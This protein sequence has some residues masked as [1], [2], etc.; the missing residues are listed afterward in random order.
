MSGREHITL[1]ITVTL[2]GSGAQQT[3]YLATEGFR[4]G[5]ADTPPTTYFAELVDSIGEY[6]RD[7]FSAARVAG[8]T[9]P[10]RL[11]ITLI[12]AAGVLDVFSRVSTGG[13]VVARIGVPGTAYP[14]AY[15]TLFVAYIDTAPADFDVVRLNVRDR[16]DLLDAPIVTAAFAGTGG[17]EGTVTAANKKQLVFGQPG[18]VPMILLDPVNQIYYVQANATDSNTIG[19]LAEFGHVFEG[20]VP[21]ERGPLYDSPNQLLGTE[22]S[23]GQYRMWSGIYPNRL[24]G[25]EFL[26]PQKTAVYTK[27]PIYVRLK[28]PP[29]FDLRFGASG[30]LQNSTSATPR[31]WRFTDMCNRAGM[32]DVTPTALAPMA[33]L[34]ED[35]DMGNRFIDG[36]QTYLDAMN[37]RAQ[38][39]QGAFGFD[40][41]DRFYCARLL[42]PEDGADASVFEFNADNSSNFARTPVPGMENPAWQVSVRAG[43]AHPGNLA[44]GASVEMQDILS[45]QDYLTSFTGTSDDVRKRFPRAVSVSLEIDGHDFPTIES[46]Q[47]FVDTFGRL[48]GTQRDFV[49]LTCHRFDSATRGIDLLSKVTLRLPR[50]GFDAGVLMR[51]VSVAPDYRSRTIRF[52][53]WGNNSGRTEWELGGGHYPAGSGDPGGSYGGAEIPQSVPS[54]TQQRD[55]LGDI[56]GYFAGAI[57]LAGALEPN[58]DSM[59]GAFT[60][61]IAEPAGDPYFANVALLMHFNGANNSSTATDSSSY[62]DDKTL[63]S[64]YVISTA[65]SK[66]N[67][68]SLL[69]PDGVFGVTPATWS[70]DSRYGRGSGQG[71]TIEAWV[72]QSSASP[73]G[74]GL[75]LDD[76]GSILWLLR[77]TGTANEWEISFRDYTYSA[78]FTASSAAWH[79]AQTVIATDG[80]SITKFDG[81]TVL[82]T[83]DLGTWS[84]AAPFISN[85]DV[86]GGSVHAADWRITPGVARA[87]AVPTEA[88]PD[89]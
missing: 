81:V 20:G 13:Q 34:V 80:T 73:S 40:R 27:G 21:V 53:L 2:D 51:V 42:D 82:T 63:S 11:T 84:T 57:S 25:A 47:A 22:P 65:Q 33:G 78:T 76:S 55:T 28:A 17:L 66:W 36:D 83:P 14:A 75:G 48:H 31:A 52:T 41:L 15:E 6:R 72:W 58:L 4:T 7:L 54:L 59:T 71:Y 32:P 62:G 45:R 1:E 26:D 56:T 89:S 49:S 38:A 9:K 64:P 30:L 74:G 19:G 61:E 60:G 35:F 24:N 50:F 44:S 88:F 79:F 12:N 8:A 46:Q 67:G 87:F 68:S 5:A 39:L 18:L 3:Y 70:Y 23:V 69:F 85:E 37:D 86:I 29:I 10:S 43:R 77:P 16:I